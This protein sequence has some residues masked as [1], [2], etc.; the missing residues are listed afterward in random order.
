MPIYSASPTAERLRQGEIVSNVF[1]AMEVLDRAG[2]SARFERKV[3]PFAIIASQDCELEQDFNAKQQN[4]LET[5]PNVLFCE[6]IEVTRLKSGPPNL[7]SDIWRRVKSNQNERYHVLQR[8]LP[9]EDAQGEGL[10]ELGIDFKRYFTMPTKEVY[11]RLGTE[12]RR[13]CFMNSPYLEHFS[14]R[15][16]HFLARVA[17][18]VEHQIDA[19]Q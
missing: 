11:F 10:P 7:P 14:D 18:P 12:I 2:G 13:R 9:A 19:A 3:H 15:F 16:C 1:Q 5:L 6:V 8:I 17:L 4:G